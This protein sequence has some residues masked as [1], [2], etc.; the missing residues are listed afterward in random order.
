[1]NPNEMPLF[2]GQNPQQKQGVTGDRQDLLSDTNANLESPP[3]L[4]RAPRQPPPMAVRR[5]ATEPRFKV[6]NSTNRHGNS[7]Y[8]VS[9]YLLGGKRV[10]EQFQDL[11]AA[12]ARCNE[13]ESQHVVHGHGA[14]LRLTRLFPEELA[15]A[16]RGFTMVDS[17]AEFECAM[18]YWVRFGKAAHGT[19][20]LPE[21]RDA[22]EQYY[23]WLES[24]E[25]GV[26]DVTRYGYKKAIQRFVE[27]AGDLN[28]GELSSDAIADILNR[29]WPDSPTSRHVHRLAVSRF[30]SWCMDRPRRWLKINP[31]SGKLIKTKPGHVLN[32]K[33]PEIFSLREV[34][35][36]LAAARRLKG[37]KFLSYIVISL[38]AGVRPREVA[39]LRQGQFLM[40]DSELRMEAGQA[41][42][43]R[44]RTIELPDVLL[45]WLK[46]CPEGKP[47]V[48]TN[49]R[50]LWDR[51]KAMA[52]IKYW[53]HDG[54]RHTAIS[55][56]FKAEGSY[57][58]SAYWAGNSE[59]VIKASYQ[60]RVSQ[61]ESDLYW[62]MYPER[63]ERL[64]ARRK[65]MTLDEKERKSSVGA[66]RTHG[67][68]SRINPINGERRRMR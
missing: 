8:M 10:R 31:A 52:K 44:S 34:M 29:Q 32:E 57:G 48:W 63:K 62:T 58:L 25:T 42:T 66:I 45:A 51:L 55:Y 46:V 3:P 41:K 6:V 12:K 14:T 67:K 54:L 24:G 60:G 53:P 19:G 30:C 1:M 26:R 15:A 9:G 68:G 40:E 23:V 11:A 65:L 59:N 37:G 22:A 2:S 13:L 27:A 49:N 61:R 21:L 56:Y 7:I 28:L 47:A 16:E 43:G 33:E 20:Q 4:K 17:V 36:I 38:F 5:S 64:A 50:A 35:R 39:R 18:N